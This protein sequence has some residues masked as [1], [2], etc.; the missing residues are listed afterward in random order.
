MLRN[1]KGDLF[2]GITAGVVALPLALAFGVQS[3]LGAAAGL[4][5]AIILGF[6]AAILGGTATQ[7]SGPTG[8]MTV[9]AASLVGMVTIHYGSLE[10]AMGAILITF[11]MAGLIQ[12]AFGLLRLGQYVRY[13]PYPVLS[14]FMS[15]IGVIIISLQLFPLIGLSSPKTLTQV[16]VEFPASLGMA[17]PEALLLAVITI[18]IIY[19]LPLITKT[20]PG[21]LVALIVGTLAA[22]V[23]NLEVPVI[24]DMPKGL[25]SLNLGAYAKL[26]F[27]DLGFLIGPAVTLAGLGAIDTLLT[28]VVADNVTHTRHDSNKELI[29]QGAGNA[30]ASF[31]GGLPG[32]GA[33]MRTLVNVKS[34]GRTR[35]SGVFHSLL[36]VLAMLGLGAYVA[37]IPFAVLAGVLVTVGIGIIDKKGLLDLIHIPR[38][39][40]ATL[41]VVLLLT[42][43]IDLLQAVGVGM[44][45]ASILFMKRAGDLVESGT[46][47]S[48]SNIDDREIPWDDESELEPKTLEKIYIQRLDGP[49]FFGAVTRF[50]Q[51][52]ESVPEGAKVVII[53]MRKV[54]YID[55][56]GLYAIETAVQDL[57]ERGVIVIFTIIQPQVMYMFQKTNLVPGLVAESLC[58]KTFEDCAH[59][60]NHWAA[61]EANGSV[62]SRAV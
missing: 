3:G 50:R 40:A 27:S 7:I 61:N 20:I 35:L 36:L 8:P 21:S 49:V 48:P 34:G 9:V 18:L 62:E 17:N 44:I 59:W 2:G 15:G 12:I 32:A 10:L 58:F 41:I 53:R 42:V 55:Q 5:G 31:F 16:L 54:P 22:Y 28:S 4:Y 6:F 23:F 24:G 56:S 43:F 30:I 33:T 52:M 11:L 60:L 51:Q 37:M 45:I 26:S 13:I 14:G 19:L 29:G 57:Q 25:P 46:N 1:L 38:A 47:L 39:D